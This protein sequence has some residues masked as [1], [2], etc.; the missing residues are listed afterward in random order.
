MPGV[1]WYDLKIAVVNGGKALAIKWAIAMALCMGFVVLTAKDWTSFVAM[2]GAAAWLSFQVVL[3]LFGGGAVAAAIE[4]S[5][6][7]DRLPKSKPERVRDTLYYEDAAGRDALQLLAGFGALLER[8][9]IATRS[10]GDL[11]FDMGEAH[12]AITA[13]PRKG[14]LWID[15]RKADAIERGAMLHRLKEYL[16]SQSVAVGGDAAPDPLPAHLR[17]AQA[18]GLV[19]RPAFG[20][21]G[22]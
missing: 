19:G 3:R 2:T 12:Y 4:S 22:L 18:A 5:G 13:H 1:M 9:G 11:Q 16:A 7:T 14:E 20:R 17:E 8:D 10:F 21:R 15:S 6:L